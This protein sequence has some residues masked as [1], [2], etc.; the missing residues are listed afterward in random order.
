MPDHEAYPM[1]RTLPTKQ[2]EDLNGEAAIDQLLREH[3]AYIQRM[4]LSILDDAH[5]A[6]DVVQET[7]I[8][9]HR[10]LPNFRQEANPKTW[11]SAIAINAS[12][13]RLR[14][15]KV[16]Q[17]LVDALH[18]LHLLKSPPPSPEQAAINTEED[19]ALWQAVDELD[20]KHRLPV[21]L[22]YVHELR[23]PEIAK[24]LR[25]SQGTVHSRLHYARQQLHAQLRH[26]VPPE[27]AQD[28]AS[29]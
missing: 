13:G 2:L 25:I 4:A 20:D 17:V 15:R 18:G 9:A 6:E 14:K 28:E 19:H 3:Y 7:F 26:L 29:K 1:T 22:R 16:R 27:E 21:I 8:A 24:I 5:E 10:A 23:I 11:L 12:R